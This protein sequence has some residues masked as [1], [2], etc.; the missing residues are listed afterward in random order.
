MKRRLLTLWK[1]LWASPTTIFGLLFLIT[2]KARIL[3]GVVEI[4]GSLARLF[5]N[6]APFC[7]GATAMTL[8]HV[9]IGQ[10]L[11]ALDLCHRHEMIHVRQYETFGPFFIPLYFLLSL[12]AWRQGDDAYYGNLFEAEAYAKDGSN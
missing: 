4:H 6:Y 2:G 5:L 7:G 8:G 12:H 1:Y 10:N 11:L 3:D 9:V